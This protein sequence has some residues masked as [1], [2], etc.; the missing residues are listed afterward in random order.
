MQPCVERLRSTQHRLGW[1]L[2]TRCSKVGEDVRDALIERSGRVQE[3]DAFLR[4]VRDSMWRGSYFC[5]VRSS[6]HLASTGVSVLDAIGGD[7][8]RAEALDEV[9]GNVRAGGYGCAAIRDR[10]VRR[11]TVDDDGMPLPEQIATQVEDDLVRGCTGGRMRD[12]CRHDRG[13]RRVVVDDDGCR[14]SPDRNSD[15]G[16]A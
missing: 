8:V 6:A 15:R 3:Q 11:R 14:C 4:P 5:C 12:T 10:L 9:V 13:L 1:A 2:C 7:V 16:L